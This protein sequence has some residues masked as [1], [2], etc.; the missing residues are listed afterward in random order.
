MLPKRIPKPPKRASRWRSQAHEKFVKGF[1]CCNCGYMPTDGTLSI[2]AHVRLGSHTGASQKPDDWRIVPLCGPHGDQ[3]GC[4]DM[5]HRVG[6]R[7]FWKTIAKRDPEAL[8]AALIKASPRR[9]EIE[10]VRRERENG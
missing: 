9:Q 4:H 3:E 1:A 5:Q 10:A 6:E 7:T 2:G 8:I